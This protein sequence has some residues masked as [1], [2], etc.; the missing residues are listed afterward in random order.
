MFC[1][2]SGDGQSGAAPRGDTGRAQ[3][4]KVTIVT[5]PREGVTACHTG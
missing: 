4:T 3:K 2:L 1:V 5:G